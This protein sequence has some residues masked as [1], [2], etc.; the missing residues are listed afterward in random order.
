M[1][2]TFIVALFAG[3]FVA[4]RSASYTVRPSAPIVGTAV[5]VLSIATVLV[6]GAVR[7]ALVPMPLLRAP[8]GSV[9]GIPP[10]VA[11]AAPDLTAA[12][13]SGDVDRAIS[14]LADP[15]V[16]DRLSATAG[17]PRDEVAS[18]LG[19]I[20]SRLESDRADPADAL[21]QARTDLQRLAPSNPT[22]GTAASAVPVPAPQPQATIAGWV[23]FFVLIVSLACAIGGAAA[24]FRPVPYVR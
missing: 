11:Q 1:F 22:S 24:G 7:L 8:V 21:A 10:A 19:N 15:S 6:F 9:A 4:T 2:F 12:L 17:V 18:T 5:W 3:G 23:S 14:R 13:S 16:A 20:R